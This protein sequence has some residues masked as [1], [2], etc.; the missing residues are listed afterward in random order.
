MCLVNIESGV[1]IELISGPPVVNLLKKG[2]TY[3]HLGYSVSDIRGQSSQLI[4]TGAIQ[5]SDPKPAV[6]F[7]NRLV[8]F[9]YCTYGLIEL[10]EE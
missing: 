10:V 7:E 3:Y 1:P 6:L 8:A 2:L 9:F 5:I 4:N